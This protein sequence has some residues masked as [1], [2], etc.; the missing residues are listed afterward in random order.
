[1]P[2]PLR[3]VSGWERH[4]A[5]YLKAHRHTPY[6]WGVNDCVTFACG[7]VAA[8]TGTTLL[9]PTWTDEATALRALVPLGGLE[10]AATSVLGAPVSGWKHAHRGDVVLVEQDGRPAL[11]IC[12]GHTLCGPNHA[13]GLAHLKLSAALKVWRVG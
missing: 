8:M 2:I 10:A 5:A 1:M 11:M 4:F 3:R 13:G 12:T 6:A 7:L 9:Q